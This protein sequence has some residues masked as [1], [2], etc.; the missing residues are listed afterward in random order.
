[1]PCAISSSVACGCF[2]RNAFVATV[3]PGVQ[4]PHCC[5]S[6]LTNAVCTGCACPLPK[7][8]AVTICLPCAS[9]ASVVHE[10]TG[11]S[12]INTVQAPHS[13]RSQTRF[14]PVMSKFSRSA[15]SRVTRG[16]RSAL[17]VFPFTLSLTG[18]APGPWTATSCPSTLITVGPTTSGTD[19]AMPDILRNSRREKLEDLSSFLLIGNSR[20]SWD[21][22][23]QTEIL[24]PECASCQAAH[25][26]AA[27]S[28]VVPLTTNPRG[29]SPD[30][31]FTLKNKIVWS[32]GSVVTEGKSFASAGT[33]L[34][35]AGCFFPVTCRLRST[36]C[37]KV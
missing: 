19:A 35:G 12:S 32:S 22:Y 24:V 34:S 30:C 13:P 21:A 9:I 4:K 15:S 33:R 29:S 31:V 6:L 36:S 11:R 1:M 17:N 27:Y 23:M 7:P 28:V 8:S 18:T 14:G 3:K 26:E 25:F 5:A 37:S 2:S 16:S 20:R 10:Y